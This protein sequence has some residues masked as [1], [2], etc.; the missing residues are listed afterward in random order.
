M[1]HIF[2]TSVLQ[3][4]FPTLWKQAAVVAVFKEVT[5]I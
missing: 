4:K 2:N 3:R 1:R 5:A